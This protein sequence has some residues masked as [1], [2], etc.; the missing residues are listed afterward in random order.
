M[1]CAMQDRL[2][3]FG[4]D[5]NIKKFTAMLTVATDDDQREM[6]ARLLTEEMAG[7]R[8]SGWS[9]TRTSG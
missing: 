1:E 7:L 6:L 8:P 3:K 9:K 2:K 5:E 4:H